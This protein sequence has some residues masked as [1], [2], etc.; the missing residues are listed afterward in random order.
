MIDSHTH[1]IAS[2]N[3]TPEKRAERAAQIR[4]QADHLGIDKLC[5]I[6]WKGDTLEECREENAIVA[7]YVEEHP[8]LFY[9]WARV[10]PSLGEE[11]VSEF[12][13]AVTEDGLIGLKQ[14]SAAAK[15]PCDDPAMDPLA[16]ACVDLDV[17]MI[18]H[19][20]HRLSYNLEERGR[21]Y[22][23][24]TENVRALAERFPDLKLISGHIGAGGDWEHRIKHIEEQENVYLDISGTNCEAGMI[25]MAVE[26]LGADRLVYGS[27]GWLIPCVGKLEGA[28]IDPE[29]KA[30]IAYKMEELLGPEV[31]NKLSNAELAERKEAAVERFAE[32]AEPLARDVID[33]NAFLGKWPFQNFGES[34]A[35]LVD[36]M[37]RKG[38]DQA[39]V[40]ATES[41][42]YRNVHSGNRELIEAIQGYE[43]R[44][45]PVATINPTY[46]AWKDDLAECLDEFGMEAVKLLPLYHDYDLSEPTVRELFAICAERGVPVI[47]AGPLE[48]SRG[49]HPR[50]KYRGHDDIRRDFWSDEQVEEMISLLGDCP[51]TDVIVADAWDHVFDIK[52]A[53]CESNP[54]GVWLENDVRS[55]ETLF[56]LGDLFMYW[57]YQGEEI[58]ERIGTEHLAVGPQLPFK[59]FDSYYKYTEQLP[60]DE[61]A[62][63]AISSDNVR[64]LLE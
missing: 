52:E 61:D 44:L 48:D 10:E 11:A 63:K 21:P 5:M 30:E 15:I 27:D 16:E 6:G 23:T 36:L 49:R 55:G 33:A 41:V 58:V 25:E 38:V 40:S 14:H 20:T 13:R 24:L 29:E 45:I 39:L 28:A 34:A 32:A 4:T 17:P 60:V 22:E 57:P 47:L 43:D 7:S 59:T 31:P 26:R 54:S 12:R 18:V 3:S 64:S 50:V 37:D 9:G 53:V 51:E 19:A 46:A 62:K 8:D 35:E 1:T 56:V 42:F 2:D